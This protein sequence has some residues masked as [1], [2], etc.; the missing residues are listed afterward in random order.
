[1]ADIAMHVLAATYVSRSNFDSTAWS[2]ILDNYT[3]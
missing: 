1:M 3:Y 2:F